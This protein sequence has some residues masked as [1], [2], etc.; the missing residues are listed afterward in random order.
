MNNKKL[1]EIRQFLLSD[2]DEYYQIINSNEF[3]NN[4]SR[5]TGRLLCLI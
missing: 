3:D 5:I 2:M 1:S 4:K